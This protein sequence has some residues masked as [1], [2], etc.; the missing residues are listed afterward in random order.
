[1]SEIIASTYEIV[2]EI[3]KG[4]GGVVYLANHMR[5][6]KKVVLKVDN[7]KITTRLDLLRREVDVLKELRHTYIPQ[8]YDYFIQDDVVY[9]VIDYI[10]GESL[11]KPLERGEK[12]SQPQVIAWAKEILQALDYL[13][14]PTHGSPAR[15]YVH[16]DIKPANIMKKPDG[17]IC[18]IDFNIALALGEE[19]AVGCSRGYASPEHYG[20]DFSSGSRESSGT[21]MLPGSRGRRTGSRSTAASVKS[22]SVG[23]SSGS[24]GKKIVVP[25]VR[26]DI[27]SLGATL[28]HLLNGKRP[29]EKAKDVI[30]LSKKEFSPQIVD[31]I[32]KAMNPN[33]DLRYQSAKEMLDAFTNLHWNDIRYIRWKRRNRI[34]Y[35]V[36]S[37]L[38]AGG[39]I[40]S[41]SGLKRMQVTE[42]WLKMAEYSENAL[43]EGDSSGAV[44]YALSALP[45]RK[46]F[47]QPPVVPEVQKALTDAAGVYDLSDGYKTYETTELPSQP[48]FM[49]LSPD[50]KTAACIY[51][52]SMMIFDTENSRI[53]AVLPVEASAL[54]E[55]EY[56]DNDT[57]IYAGEGGIR[58]YSISAAEELWAGNPATAIALSA[59]GKR[60]AAVYKDETSA[61]IYDTANGKVITAVDFQGR[62]QWTAPNDI[63]ANPQN[64]ILALNG[65]GSLMA[66]SFS[67]GSLA[68]YDL[69]SGEEY[70]TL[71]DNSS[72]YTRFEGGF[73][74]QYF[75]FSAAGEE[76][77]VF[78]V[79]D[80]ELMEQTG[81]FQTQDSYYGVKVSDTGIYVQEDNILVNLHPVSGENRP[82][83]T[84]SENIR[85]FDTD[86]V[87]TLITTNDAFLFFDGNAELME[88][89]END[90]SGDFVQIAG[91]TALV[92]SMDSPFVRILKYENHPE[93]QL[94]SYDLSFEHAEARRSLDGNTIMLFDYS[95]FRLYS[96]GGD[97]ITEVSI[98]DPG[99]VY[100]QQYIRDEDGSRLEVYYKDGRIA[101]Y[102]AADGMLLYEKTGDV[103]DMTLEEEFLTDEYRIVSRLHEA[104]E[105]YDRKSGKLVCRLKDDDSLTYVTQIDGGI[106]T[107][108]VTADG[109]CYGQLLD[110][111]CKII[112]EL[113]YLCDVLDESL[114]F[115]Y[116]DGNLRQSR[117]Y[118]ID[119]ITEIA[120]S[121]RGVRKH[122]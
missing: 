18:L 2:E 36:L 92:G 112:A 7:R 66:E 48:F 89:Y 97:L 94:F 21:E 74:Q 26:S 105:V 108:Y 27:Y 50:G 52:Y 84:C 99:E 41:F 4:G 30:P 29:N 13:H 32:T 25:D 35:T 86:G 113:P 64:N 9:T 90:S 11:D 5:L 31:I 98:P 120:K 95:R 68:V 76:E 107:Q 53:L 15:G 33:P 67:D 1:M 80:T 104:P 61:M 121:Q 72:G 40:C 45:E 122:A 100:D 73:Y 115:D 70:L 91:E 10:D 63:Y 58:A 111:K 28:Y 46:N 17:H 47:L 54:A 102:S 87:H 82:M 110:E 78:A 6:K 59:D 79:V 24:S 88:R 38:L 77:A 109:Y 119:E 75:A 114:I 39:G 19:N 57:V 14:S 117:V 71:F 23:S 116:P 118:L 106:V 101:A 85:R 8:V 44:D 93:S 37:L 3:G 42:Q 12:F 22:S 34:V 65:D 62:H 60:A 49:E 69:G 55:V 51:A 16:S 20:V 56:L 96:T 83:V 43:R 103:P 81:G